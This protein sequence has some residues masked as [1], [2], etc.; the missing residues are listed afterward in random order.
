MGFWSNFFAYAA[1]NFISDA[2]K[3]TKKHNDM[4]KQLSEYEEDM[5]RYLSQIGC[6][7]VYIAD[8]SCIETGSTYSEKCRYELT[9]SKIIEYLNLG[10]DPKALS[11]IDNIDDYISKVKFLKSIGSLD[12]QFEFSEYSAEQVES[13]INKEKAKF[14][15]LQPET[16]FVCKE[17]K[18]YCKNNEY[19]IPLF[20]DDLGITSGLSR[21]LTANEKI[22]RYNIL[23][24]ELSE[25]NNNLKVRNRLISIL[26]NY[27]FTPLSEF[28]N[29]EEK[30]VLNNKKSC[31]SLLLQLIDVYT[32]Y[33][34]DNIRA[35]R[36]KNHFLIL[37][38]TLFILLCE[39]KKALKIYQSLLSD[40]EILQDIKLISKRKE[41]RDAENYD[42]DTIAGIIRDICVIYNLCGFNE[43]IKSIKNQ[44]A[45]VFEAIKIRDNRIALDNPNLAEYIRES[46]A[47]ICC[48]SF[49][50]GK[51][52]K[53]NLTNSGYHNW[54]SELTMIDALILDANAPTLEDNYVLHLKNEELIFAND[55]RIC[56]KQELTEKELAD[57]SYEIAII[58]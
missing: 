3:E 45:S 33:L 26:G 4:C 31:A 14:E 42:I 39:F 51:F 19:P 11:W 1:A 12:R 24:E 36:V 48:N 16:V 27:I 44:Y 17:N 41:Y 56:Y 25:D 46:T 21:G 40:E 9:K 57:I 15:K 2:Q 43:K 52:Y 38:A 50:T 53:D 32:S 18:N 37:K 28:E 54:T 10:G 6:D 5:N 29:H 13:I 47:I 20:Y 58:F 49:S 22:K 55:N 30:L 34:G 8:Y 35:I 7:S 23:L